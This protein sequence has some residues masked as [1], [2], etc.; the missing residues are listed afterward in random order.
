MKIFGLEITRAPR[1]NADARSVENPS[2][3]LSDP[4][5]LDALGI[6]DGVI[7]VSPNTAMQ[8]RAVFSCV[9]VISEAIGQL[10]IHL[11]RRIDDKRRERATNHPSA[12]LI[13]RRPSP[14]MTRAT[15]FEQQTAQMCLW[16]AAY[17]QRVYDL[18]TD[19]TI[20]LYP[21]Q[22]S[23]VS[24]A[25]IEVRDERGFPALVR[26]FRKGG[27]IYS[28]DAVLHVPLLTL[29][30]I[31]GLSPIRQN[32]LAISVAQQ[33]Q[34]FSERFYA[35][36]VKLS[37]V[38]EHP[39]RLSPEAS[40][41]LR[42]NWTS[43]YAGSA[44][45]G[46]VAILEEGM[47]FNGLVMPLED[48]QFIETAKLS[49]EEIAGI[50]RVPPHMIGHLEKATFSNIEHQSL[51]FAVYTL[52]PYLVKWEQALAD[53]L[54]GEDEHDEYYFRF[55]LDALARGDLKSR[56]DAYA[57]A[58]QWGWMSA[59]DILELEDRNPIENGDIYLQPLN[60]IPAGTPL[61]QYLKAAGSQPAGEKTDES[62]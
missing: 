52:S 60:M 39:N 36:G 19:E 20:A 50:F 26:Q 30:G 51:E 48:A 27:E 35:N 28:D 9:K 5:I 13:G 6:G 32:R 24:T 3:S 22:S 16:G 41:R 56:S 18:R 25:A 4:K 46:K 12:R 42:D 14:L 21:W 8:V 59:N 37:G 1:V 49:R 53:S 7:G 15:Y 34:R 40:D 10:P 11:Y 31:T 44:N 38:L 47:K 61:D 58:R 45:A 55:N 29:D 2:F 57:V 33:Q 54:L 17:S 43:V 62:S 23:Q